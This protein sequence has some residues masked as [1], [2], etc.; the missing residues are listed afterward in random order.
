[1]SVNVSLKKYISLMNTVI[2]NL[3]N[4]TYHF[5]ILYYFLLYLLFLY[6]PTQIKCDHE[7]RFSVSLSANV[8]ACLCSYS[9]KYSWT[10]L[11]YLGLL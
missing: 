2:K 6:F 3:F 7:F 5:I 10:L 8:P 1:M 11:C 4:F 9:R